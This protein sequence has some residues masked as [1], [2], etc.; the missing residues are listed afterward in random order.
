[1]PIEKLKK[2]NNKKLNITPKGLEQLEK[3]KLQ[4]VNV[5]LDKIVEAKE[6][7]GSEEIE[8][9]GNE[10][11]EFSKNFVYRD[12]LRM[13]RKKHWLM[14][15]S[16]LYTVVGLFLIILG[17][18]YDSFEYILKTSPERAALIFTGITIF[19]VGI[20]AQVFFTYQ[21]RKMRDWKK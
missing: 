12:N 4:Q 5:L 7:P 6:F 18:Y 10:I 13:A 17:I 3:F 20:F 14:L 8:I 21:N 16:A 1:M 2:M 15:L 19:L 11:V 9:S